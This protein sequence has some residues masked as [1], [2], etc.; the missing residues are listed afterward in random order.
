LCKDEKLCTHVPELTWRSGL[1]DRT[2]RRIVGLARRQA[3]TV[4]HFSCFR[5]GGTLK[6]L[7]EDVFHEWI[8]YLLEGGLIGAYL[9]LDFF[10]SYY[11]YHK[12][13]SGK[14]PEQLTLRLLLHDAFFGK[15]EKTSRQQMGDFHWKQVALRFLTEYQ[16]HALSIS[17]RLL[18]YF[19]IEGT[20]IG[21]YRTQ[22][23]EVLIQIIKLYPQ[24]VWQQT[25]KYIG[26]PLDH[27]AFDLTQWLREGPLS[28]FPQDAIWAWV[29]E[30]REKRSSHLARFVPKSLSGGNGQQSLARAVL[31]RYGHIED[32]RHSFSA[33]Y[34]SGAW[35]GP[36][37]QHFLARQK[38]LLEL[39]AK[40]TD[41]NVRLW[42]DEYLDALEKDLERA[43]LQEERRGF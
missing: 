16:Q 12:K 28:L 10:D 25:S 35:T 1:T 13:G 4:E 41:E 29:E 5:M 39:R 42:I 18:G 40:E 43:Q 37:T 17:E 38:E 30:D 22:V 11:L 33:N 8:D 3:I 24:E 14:L 36:E 7:S 27:R 15:A 31:M 2:G 21:G 19:G 34:F 20:I 6:A 9:A 32:V 23:Q 26:P